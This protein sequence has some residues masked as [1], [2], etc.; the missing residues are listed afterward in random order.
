MFPSRFL[1]KSHNCLQRYLLNVYFKL[2]LLLYILFLN[3]P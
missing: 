3:F 2:T 1:P